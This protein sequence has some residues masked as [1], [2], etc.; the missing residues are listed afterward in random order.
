MT[1]SL[2]VAGV[3]PSTLRPRPAPGVLRYNGDGYGDCEPA[4]S[5]NELPGQRAS[6]GRPA[7]PGTGHPWPVLSGENGEYQVLAGNPSA[8]AAD[9]TSC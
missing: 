9:L 8:A 7:T 1:N 6:R 5:L 4:V 3:P 2:A